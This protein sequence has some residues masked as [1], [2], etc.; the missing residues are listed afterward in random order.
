MVGGIN[1]DVGRE[2][3]VGKIQ[4]RARLG[5]VEQQSLGIRAGGVAEI[6]CPAWQIHIAVGPTEGDQCAGGVTA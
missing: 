6:G 3:C 5:A 4:D 2:I 1:R